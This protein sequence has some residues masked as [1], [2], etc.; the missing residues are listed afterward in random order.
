VYAAKECVANVHE[1]EENEL[2]TFL[3]LLESDIIVMVDAANEDW[4]R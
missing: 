2:C 1:K 3:L 4:K